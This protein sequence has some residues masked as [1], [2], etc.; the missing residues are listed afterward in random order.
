MS[1]AL[2]LATALSLMAA[3]AG[4]DAE[5]VETFVDVLT[6]DVQPPS[7]GDDVEPVEAKPAYFVAEPEEPPFE[8]VTIWRLQTC[9][10]GVLYQLDSNGNWILPGRTE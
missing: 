4:C 6:G 9:E 2:R 3:L 5:E 7:A 1:A 10:A 8:C